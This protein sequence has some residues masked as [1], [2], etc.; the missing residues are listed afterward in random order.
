MFTVAI[1]ASLTFPVYVLTLTLS[2]TSSAITQASRM[3]RREGG[4][5]AI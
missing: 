1:N 4:R 2:Y 5:E 3:V